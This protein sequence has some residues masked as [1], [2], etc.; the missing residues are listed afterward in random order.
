MAK[1]YIKISVGI[2]FYLVMIVMDLL[3][4][5]E[6]DIS[7]LMVNGF[8]AVVFTTLWFK[9][10]EKKRLYSKMG[11]QGAKTRQSDKYHL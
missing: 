5:H 9:V 8:S 2:S 1:N 10:F 7:L 6:I 11:R 3:W 4:L